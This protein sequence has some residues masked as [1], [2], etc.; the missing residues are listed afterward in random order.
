[1]PM[2]LR[3][4]ESRKSEL[5]VGNIMIELAFK[6]LER[7]K[8]SPI[9]EQRIWETRLRCDHIASALERH[10]RQVLSES[11]RLETIVARV[12]V[13]F[14]F[15]SHQKNDQEFGLRNASKGPGP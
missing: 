7:A 13:I 10:D 2:Q 11:A 14:P 4:E 12:P 3:A 8:Q 1:M 5:L 9:R 6:H 15:I